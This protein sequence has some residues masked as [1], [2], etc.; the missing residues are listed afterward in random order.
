MTV[1]Q[2]QDCEVINNVNRVIADLDH[3]DIEFAVLVR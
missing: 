3:T 1:T 2:Q